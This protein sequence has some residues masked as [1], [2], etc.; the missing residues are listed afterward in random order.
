MT[1]GT[2]ALIAHVLYRFDIGGLENGIVNLIN[3]LPAQTFRHAVV[4]LTDVTDFKAR[5]LRDDV[6]YV[7]LHKPAGHGLGIY[8]KLYATFRRMHPDVVHT[9]NLAALEAQ[10]PAAAAGVP[11]RLHGE[12]GWDVH[13]L[14]KGRKSHQWERRLLSPFVH[15]YIALSR[16]TQIYLNRS[17]GINSRRICQIYNGVDTQT[18]VPASIAARR[19][20]LPF[21]EENLFVVGTVGRLEAVKDQ[22]LLARAFVRALAIAPDMRPYLRLVIVGDGFLRAEIEAL[23]REAGCQKMVW[24]AGAREDIPE[25]LR[26][27]DLFVLPSL[28]EGISNT[29]LEAMASGLPVVATN[30]GGNS[31]LVDDGIT[32]ALVASGDIEALARAILQYAAA[33]EKSR[34]QGHAGRIRAEQKFSIESMVANYASLY[35]AALD[36][37]AWP[38]ERS[39]ITPQP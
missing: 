26:S 28:A 36:H 12:H 35:R 24:L 31:E 38:R 4:A 21:R 13:D 3:R 33:P 18:F 9:R 5:V 16:D 2:Q 30:V 10:V 20:E 6:Q 15:R 7:S 8:A 27:F 25:L 39:A 19:V 29:I 1:R 32:G 23:V 34:T 17:V 37:R 11:A 14:G 22:G